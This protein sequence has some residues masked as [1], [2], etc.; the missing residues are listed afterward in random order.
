[1]RLRISLGGRV[2][3]SVC[4]S[5]R[6]SFRPS[7]INFER[8]IWL[9]LRVKSNLNIKTSEQWVMKKTSH[10]TY[11]RSTSCVIRHILSQQ[12]HLLVYSHE[13]GIPYTQAVISRA[14]FRF[15]FFCV[16]ASLWE[17]LSVRPSVIHE[18]NFREMLFLGWIR[19]KKT[20]QEPEIMPHEA[21]LREKYPSSSSERFWSDLFIKQQI[22]TF[23]PQSSYFVV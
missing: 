8:R 11:P 3:L 12:M 20:H 19:T 10:L 7:P 18:L 1:M 2:C 21:Q 16:L 9:F 15:L 22:F 17:V 5:V 6:C 13:S 14:K 4:P 23:I